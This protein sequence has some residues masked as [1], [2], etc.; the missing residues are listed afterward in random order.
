MSPVSLDKERIGSVEEGLR[1]G[2]SHEKIN[3]ECAFIIFS[4]FIPL[5]YAISPFT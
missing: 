5:F 3:K 4:L 1:D 2:S